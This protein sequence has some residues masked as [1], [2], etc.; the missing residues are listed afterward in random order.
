MNVRGDVTV[1]QATASDVGLIAPLFDA[2]RQFYRKPSDLNLAHRFLLERLQN[3]QSV[4][5][6]AIRQD[7]SAVGFA[8][9]FPSFSSASAALIF[10][11]NDLFVVPEARRMGVASLLLDTATRFGQIG[12]AVR[13]T[14]STEVTNVTAQALYEARG[15]KRQTDFYVYNLLI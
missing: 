11:L 2:Y 6:V 3:N 9:L 13:L 5:F 15:W 10:I 4:L 12:G 7:G 14:L 1:R 8:Q